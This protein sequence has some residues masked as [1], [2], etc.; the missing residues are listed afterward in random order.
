VLLFNNEIYGLTKGQ[1]SPTSRVGTRSPSTPFGSLDSP[2]RPCAFALGSGARF[3][4]RGIDVHK[5]LPKVL[6]AAHAHQG[7]GFV[8]I[9]QN[10]IV[11][12]DDVFAPFTAKPNAA[13]NQLW[14]EHGEPLL[15]DNGTKGLALD[16]DHLALKV[17]DVADGDW[18][19]AGVIRHD[20]ASR[21]LA[22][23]LVEMPH[24][25]F[26]VALGVIYDNPAPSF[27]SAVVEQNRAASEGKAPD[28]QKLLSN[29]QTWMVD[30]E[31]RPE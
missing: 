17:V 4:A 16:V 15:F 9:F 19:A 21:S 26:P 25:G 8:E 13:A 2:A 7:T 3:V 14:V 27:E 5:N 18:E 28:L 12:N 22:H 24:D 31:P 29:G 20:Q 1:Y 11:Y 23:M 30:K 6:K 10:C